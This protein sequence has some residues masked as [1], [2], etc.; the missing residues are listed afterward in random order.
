MNKDYVER[1]PEPEPQPAATAVAASAPNPSSLA[2]RPTSVELLL[3]CLSVGQQPT[4]DRRP[5]TADWNEVVALANRHGLTPLLYVRLKQA[6]AQT[7]V[8]ADVWER[9]R[10][11]YKASAVRS[12]CFQR[13]VR[14][15]LQRL[16][17]AGIRVIALKGAFLAEA[18]YDDPALRPMVDVDL[19]VPKADLPRAYAALLDL[20]RTR[21][22]PQAEAS[23]AEDNH[24]GLTVG[25][26]IDLRWTID[27]PGGRSRLDTTGLWERARPATIAGVEVLALSPEDLLL[28]ICLHASHRHGLGD[29][30]RPLCDVAETIRRLQREMDWQQVAQRAREWGATRHVGLMLQLARSMLDAGVPDAVLAQLV[31]GGIPRCILDAARDSVLTRSSHM[32]TIPLFRR[33][34]ARSLGERARLARERAFLSRDE[35]AVVYPAART[36]RHLYLYYARRLLAVIR[37]Y[38]SHVIRRARLQLG[39]RGRDPSAALVRWLNGRS[40]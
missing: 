4:D 7:R 19:M 20:G 11:V 35:L 25:A 26:G 39:T 37:T 3:R 9:M 23:S 38:F 30:L 28:H 29:G 2:P 1:I 6:D 31:P 5:T 22:Q 8:P 16:R 14:P 36:S 13:D 15:A 24:R 40:P 32:E 33:L 10:R 27:T 21:R 12:M 17:G 34:G 18:V